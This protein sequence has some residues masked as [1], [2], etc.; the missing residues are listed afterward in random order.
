VV[1]TAGMALVLFALCYWLVDA[2]NIRRPFV[3]LIVF[4]VNPIAVYVLSTAG[5][6]LMEAT[7]IHGANLRDRI[8]HALFTGGASPAA[9]SLLFALAYVVL[10][11]A[12]M[13]VLYRRK[14]FVRI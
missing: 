5:G 12:V 9:A 11:L 3:P 8:Y 2:K 13:S 4:G 10:W 14:I 6:A 7:T 1:F